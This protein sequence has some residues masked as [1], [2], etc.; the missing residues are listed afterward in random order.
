MGEIKFFFTCLLTISL[1]SYILLSDKAVI[2]QRSQSMAKSTQNNPWATKAII[3]AR[4]STEEQAKD[5]HYS[6]PAQLRI[7]RD[8]VKTG[9]KFGTIREI[10]RELQFDESAS[11][12][13]RKKFEEAIKIVEQSQ[14]PTAIVAERVDRFQRSFRESVRFEDLRRQGKVEL[15]FVTQ[16]LFLHR[17]SRASDLQIWDM[18]VMLARA[19]VLAI[20]DNVKRSIREKLAQGIFP[21]YA[22][23]GYKNVK[24]RVDED[25]FKKEIIVDNFQANLIKRAFRMMLT[26]KYSLV[27]LAEEMRKLGMKA[28][29]K[30]VR[31]GGKLI[32]KDQEPITSNHLYGILTNPFYTGKFFFRNPDTGEREL[33][34]K[35]NTKAK[36]Y[37]AI[38]DWK[39]Y[40]EVQ[41]IL[42]SRNN[43][44]KAGGKQL[45]DF[46]FAKMLKCG[47]C[48][49]TLTAEDMA[50]TWKKTRKKPKGDMVYY[51]CT[52]AQMAKDANY[53]EKKFGWE[54]SGV[55]VYN[56][57]KVNRC[58][59]RWWTE[60]EVEKQILWDLER[61]R[62]NEDLYS[63]FKQEIVDDL[64]SQMELAEEQLK[65]LRAE[66]TSL[67]GLFASLVKKIAL[68][69]DAEVE[70][71]FREQLKSVRDR[72][73]DIEQEIS[74]WEQ[75]KEADFDDAISALESCR[76]LA[77]RYK[78]LDVEGQR[79]FLTTLFSEMRLSKGIIPRPGNR[80][81]TIEVE[82]S[83]FIWREDFQE[84]WEIGLWEYAKA[85]DK[86][87]MPRFTTSLRKKEREASPFM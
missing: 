7:L 26:R 32:Q 43:G 34:P 82:D 76:N 29:T 33:Y 57:K 52:S 54:H 1:R 44:L 25:I 80:R 14:E 20:S 6:I 21:G 51:R 87:N 11:T 85:E 72:K 17:N 48:G 78:S 65:G 15:H 8:Y 70:K 55:T 53:Y 23:V 10:V 75:V 28:K 27:S 5:G 46:K 84:L 2:G 31:V 24:K 69:Q 38:I 62:F 86:K 66:Q 37:D 60:T 79:E 39:V 64:A 74:E 50:R 83:N 59:Q 18:H 19:F 13:R 16:G 77:E 73:S 36:N 68:E 71:A 58:P 63:R 47:F 4:V 45:H 56:K 12:D 22:P 42:Q 41:K 81:K 49:C 61:V 3:L 67:E 40:E 30:R 35:D 9:G